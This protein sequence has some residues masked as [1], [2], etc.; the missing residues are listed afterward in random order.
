LYFPYDRFIYISEDEKRFFLLRDNDITTVYKDAFT[1]GEAAGFGEFIRRKASEKKPLLTKRQSNF[2]TFRQSILLY[3]LLTVLC[4]IFVPNIWRPNI[5]LDTLEQQMI[6][7]GYDVQVLETIELQGGAVVLAVSG[8]DTVEAVLLR[9]LGNQY[10]IA[11]THTY[12]I[13]EVVN[14][15]KQWSA[16]HGIFESQDDL[17]TFAAADWRV[18]YGV[19][20]AAWWNSNQLSDNV[21]QRYTVVEFE[22]GAGE[23]ILYYRIL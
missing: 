16:A 11:D 12:H 19:A 8:I 21:K 2:R 1:I 6:K 13:T 3:V 14:Y 5:R 18:V 4:F 20:E 22:L 15:N 9:K 10:S 17:L 23:F 7:R